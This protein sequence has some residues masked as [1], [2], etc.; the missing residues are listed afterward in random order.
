MDQVFVLLSAYNQTPGLARLSLQE[1]SCSLVVVND[2]KVSLKE[3]N[4][5]QPCYSPRSR[6]N[7]PAAQ[8][9]IHASGANDAE[10][11]FAG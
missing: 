4:P 6:D 1:M 3:K 2:G 5:H 10:R 8:F 11:K 7:D 9:A